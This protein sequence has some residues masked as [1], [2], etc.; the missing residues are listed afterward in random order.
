MDNQI[1]DRRSHDPRVLAVIERLDGTVLTVGGHTKDINEIQRRVDRIESD[2]RNAIK[3]VDDHDNTLKMVSTF[4]YETKAMHKS[5]EEFIKAQQDTN[6]MFMGAQERTANFQ[7]K[8]VMI[9]G[10]LFLAWQM[11]GSKLFSAAEVLIK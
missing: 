8:L 5:F 7:N 4:I 1:P 9:G 3:N 2:Q 6:K 11:F 10:S